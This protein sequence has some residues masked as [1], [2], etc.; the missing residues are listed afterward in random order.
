MKELSSHARAAKLI[1]QELKKV[2]PDNKFSVTSRS[3]SGGNSIDIS[4]LDGVT[5][6]Q[7]NN[8][9]RKYQYGHFDGMTDSYEYS[10]VVENLP[11]VQFV[12]TDRRI[13]E[14]IINMAYECV[15]YTWQCF[16]DIKDIDQSSDKIMKTHTC[17]TARDWLRRIL[18]RMDLTNGLTREK[19]EEAIY[20]RPSEII[21]AA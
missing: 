6:E 2:F 10:N 8:I 3:Y 5:I 9:A 16:K 18:F 15:R 20:D 4:W 14:N 12:Q 19:L 7:V 17:W 11:Q 13:S 1:R 21:E